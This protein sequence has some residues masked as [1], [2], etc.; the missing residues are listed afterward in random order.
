MFFREIQMKSFLLLK[1][2]SRRRLE[3]PYYERMCYFDMQMRLKYVVS[4][5]SWRYY[6]YNINMY[7][8]DCL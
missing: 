2:I 6:F 4:V 1:V 8:S 7:L 5:S 3:D